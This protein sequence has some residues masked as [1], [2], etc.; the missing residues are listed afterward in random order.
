MRVGY[1]LQVTCARPTSGVAPGTPG[2]TVH[3]MTTPLL[4]SALVTAIDHVGIAG[5]DHDV[6]IAGY[7]AVLG[8]EDTHR[9]TTTEQGVE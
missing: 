4:P 3:G 8:L 7:R 6:A 1:A 2:A 9:E 5:P